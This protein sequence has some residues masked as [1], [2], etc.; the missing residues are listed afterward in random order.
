V[1][2]KL[3]IIIGISKNTPLKLGYYNLKEK[4]WLKIWWFRKKCVPLQPI[5][6]NRLR[7]WA[8]PRQKASFLHSVCTI[9]APAL[10]L[11]GI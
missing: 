10:I 6:I 2:A 1:N 9:I 8:A 7:R 11:I 3:L 5:S 4:S